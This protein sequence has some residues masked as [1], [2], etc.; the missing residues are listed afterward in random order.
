MYL[1]LENI[2]N[3]DYII[4]GLN[5]IEEDDQKEKFLHEHIEDA[6][7]F[8]ETI[9]K[10]NKNKIPIGK[11]KAKRKNKE[12]IEMDLYKEEDI[13]TILCEKN[14]VEIMEEYSLADLKRMY[15]SIYEKS[16]TSNY[17]KEKIVSILRNRMH[18]MRRAEAF[19]LLAEKRNMKN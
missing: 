17:T 12:V 5:D 11:K 2:N 19:A 8:L 1:S 6:D 10:V 14:N 18:T 4:S 16:P 9:K 13:Y 3:L 7:L 15:A